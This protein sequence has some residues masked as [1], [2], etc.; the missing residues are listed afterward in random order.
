MQTSVRYVHYILVLM[1]IIQLTSYVKWNYIYLYYYDKL[2]MS[3]QTL[4]FRH[5][6]LIS[7]Y[8]SKWDV[9]YQNKFNPTCQGK[10]ILQNT[11]DI[12]SVS[13]QIKF[14]MLWQIW[15]TRTHIM[16][17]WMRCDVKT[18]LIWHVRTSSYI[19]W[20]DK[21]NLTCQEKCKFSYKLTI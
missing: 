18:N 20:W 17:T 4:V 1:Y 9:W 12:A 5:D 16:N 3:G 6:N 11:C 14:D 19:K 10:Y 8:Q 2:N 7:L 21:C 13:E 15:F